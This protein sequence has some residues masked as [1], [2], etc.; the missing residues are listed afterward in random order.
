MILT[1]ATE[2]VIFHLS[3]RLICQ[4]KKDAVTENRKIKQKWFCMFDF[5]ILAQLT[6]LI[7]GHPNIKAIETIF[8]N[9]CIP[10]VVTE[11]TDTLYIQV[12]EIYKLIKSKK[13]V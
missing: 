8:N 5:I 9:G 12:I 6:I 4:L 2:P 10:K 3:K 1:D 7:F 13:K 11:N